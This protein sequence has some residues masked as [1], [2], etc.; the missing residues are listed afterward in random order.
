MLTVDV[1]KN[2]VGI[3]AME[4]YFQVR[5]GQQALLV[6]PPTGAET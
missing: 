3:R 6:T 4:M 5:Q 1:L 2:A